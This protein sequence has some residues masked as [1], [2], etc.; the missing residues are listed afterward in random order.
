MFE[1]WLLL[2][3]L[4]KDADVRCMCRS[5]RHSPRVRVRAR[6]A[7]TSK[8]HRQSPVDCLFAI[9]FAY[10]RVNTEKSKFVCYNNLNVVLL[11]DVFSY[12]IHRANRS[13][14][15]SPTSTGCASPMAVFF[16]T[17]SSAPTF[18]RAIWT[19][20]LPRCGRPSSRFLTTAWT[21]PLSE[22]TVVVFVVLIVLSHLA[23]V[24][25]AKNLQIHSFVDYPACIVIGNC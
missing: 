10:L 11:F 17:R 14:T 23:L 19:L 21:N 18:V 8:Y 7:A 24:L 13:S 1:L 22:R 9:V 15:P 20:T 25:F 12:V 6:P 16:T 4:I 2:L 3:L 5:G